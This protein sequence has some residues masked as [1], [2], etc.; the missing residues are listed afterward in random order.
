MIIKVTN[1]NSDGQGSFREALNAKGPRIIIF[2]VGGI[3]DLDKKNLSL[4]EPF[5]TIAGQTSPSPGITLIRG[6]MTITT[7]DV[8]I[9][10]IRF[11]MGDAGVSKGFEPDVSTYGPE[12]YNIVIDHC[13]FA[14]GVDENM[15]VSGPRFEGIKGTSRK[16]TLS[17]NIIAECLNN[18]IHSKG[19]HSMG[20]LVHDFCTEVAVIGNLYAH[21]SER[22][23]WFK[24]Y[25]TGVIVNNIIYNPEKWSIRLGYVAKEWAG[26]KIKPRPPR[27]V[28]IGNY[29]KHGKN[30]PDY[31][32]II[33][34]NSEGEAYIEDN[35][36]IKKTGE[37]ASLLA[38]N[39]KILKKKPLWPKGLTA[40][41]SSQIV[42]HVLKN[43]GARPKDRDSV[44]K[45]IINDFI[46][47]KGRLLNSQEEVGGYPKVKATKRALIVPD[48][49]INEWLDS[50]TKEVE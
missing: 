48:K 33:G 16:I 17:N 22:N 14:W 24:G 45:R 44:D 20:T 21:N 28:I 47:N 25:A 50:F 49:D 4:N 31:L 36:A 5:V 38:G 1:L 13:S 43:A 6:G 2:E 7:H 11:R 32:S 15:S 9:K 23:P 18:S 37:K 46:E 41:P 26:Q 27:V 30:T 35:I 40:L 3:I 42:D 12:A 29:M 34:T 10:H 19:A 39:I 8:L